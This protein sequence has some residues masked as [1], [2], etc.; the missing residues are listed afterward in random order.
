MGRQNRKGRGD[1]ALGAVAVPDIAAAQ[2]R[3]LCLGT[4]SSGV[5]HRLR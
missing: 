1:A 4:V 5:L 2:S 3:L